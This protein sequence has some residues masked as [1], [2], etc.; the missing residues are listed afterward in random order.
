MSAY[1][2]SL[3][4]SPS[5]P[6]L[7]TLLRIRTAGTAPGAI[8]VISASQLDSGGR[9]WQAVAS[10]VADDE[11]VV[12]TTSDAPLAGSY[13]GFD[14]MGLVWSMTR[15]DTP[16][17]GMR[18]G[19]L[20]PAV[21]TITA[22]HGDGPTAV[23][24]VARARLP[25]GVVRVPVTAPGIVGVMFRPEDGGPYPGV[26]LLGGSEGGLHEVDAALLAGR[27]FSV[28]ALAYFGVEGV[29]DG[30]VDL[31]LETFGT[32]IELMLAQP[33]V[34]GDRVGVLGGSRGGEAALLIGATFPR[35]GA[36][37]STVGSGLVTAGI[38]RAP[39][40][41]E[42]LRS[43]AGSW[44]WRGQT[45]PHLRYTIDQSL[46]DQVES[47]EPVELARA[48]RPDLASRREVAAATI[49]VERIRGPVL[50]LS[51]GDDRMWPSSDLSDIALHR[52]ERSRHSFPFEHVSYPDA[53]HAIAP[54]PYGP[55][56]LFAPGPGVRLSM[57]GSV[58]ATSRARADAWLRTIEWFAEH[59]PA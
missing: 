38:H 47:G 43:D 1:P 28:L 41:L 25:A 21:L 29:P 51:S 46:L 58:P 52:L 12:D 16:P 7:D 56:E 23:T 18:A 31:P 53:G 19:P 30:L 54:P 57:G 39:T 8:V 5:E 34:R 9:R 40:L 55:T 15:Q 10:F 17:E 3:T 45:V 42:T 48:F 2:P 49:P 24:T 11:G 13:E 6:A 20:D 59:L 27:G 32:A 35:V 44:T 4:V 22:K 26:L 37:V 36:V 50:L 14:A 33:W